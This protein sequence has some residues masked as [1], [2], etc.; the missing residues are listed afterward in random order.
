MRKKVI[1]KREQYNRSYQKQFVNRYV[2]KLNTRHDS[3]L[4]EYLEQMQN[5]S[6]WFKAK[7]EEAAG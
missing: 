6:A 3:K 7:L 1:T 5:R 4:I 2:F